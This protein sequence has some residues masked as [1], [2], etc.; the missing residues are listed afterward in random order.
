MF[1]RSDSYEEQQ[2]S[3]LE[4]W[5]QSGTLRSNVISWESETPPNL[6][7]VTVLGVSVPISEVKVNEISQA[8]KY[9][10][11]FKVSNRV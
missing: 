10:T 2:Y 11:V 3:Y 1:S 8:F 4:F 6:G 5:L 9:D 7:T